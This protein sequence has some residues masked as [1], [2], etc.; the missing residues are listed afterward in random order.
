MSDALLGVIIGGTFGFLGAMLGILANAWL[1]A[2]R[3]KRERRG[4]VDGAYR[5]E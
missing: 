4:P 5:D 1:D 3:A 2:R